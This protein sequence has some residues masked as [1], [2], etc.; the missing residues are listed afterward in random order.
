MWI[1]A[2]GREFS[3]LFSKKTSALPLPLLY[4]FY[5][6]TQRCGLAPLGSI[7]GLLYPCRLEPIFPDRLYFHERGGSLEDATMD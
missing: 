3:E 2:R 6:L 7:G 4:S 1:H 5:L